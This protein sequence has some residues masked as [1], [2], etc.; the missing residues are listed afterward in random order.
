MSSGTAQL[1]AAATSIALA[2]ERQYQQL[3]S[4]Y[5]QWLV[6]Q[7][8][9]E[10]GICPWTRGN[11]PSEEDHW[12]CRYIQESAASA[13]QAAKIRTALTRFYA[14]EGGRGRHGWDSEQAK[15]NPALSAVVDTYIKA[16]SR[17]KLTEHYD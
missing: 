4:A 8:V 17:R 7:H 6:A 15:G 16:L 5:A 14:G 9:I 1:S 13:N 11:I 2:T 3:A 10:D 12:I